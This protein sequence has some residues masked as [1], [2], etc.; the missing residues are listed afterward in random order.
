MTRLAK[1][2][3]T[4]AMLFF[5]RWRDTDDDLPADLAERITDQIFAGLRP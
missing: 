2:A 3:L 5:T 1:A 4:G